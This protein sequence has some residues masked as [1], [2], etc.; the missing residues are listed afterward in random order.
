VS[1]TLEQRHEALAGRVSWREC[2]RLTWLTG[3]LLAGVGRDRLRRWALEGRPGPDFERLVFEGDPEVR[4]VVLEV[5]RGMPAPFSRFAI[6]TVAFLGI[7]ASTCGWAAPLCQGRTYAIVVDGRGLNRE[8]L[9]GVV[10]HEVSHCWAGDVMDQTPSEKERADYKRGRRA[11]AALAVQAGQVPQTIAVWARRELAACRLT[12]R[13][14]FRGPG[15]DVLR[16][17]R[18][19]REEFRDAAQAAAI[20]GAAEGVERVERES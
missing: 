13:L 4:D 6:E 9:A 16:A 20:E 17:R 2:V 12:A 11:W 19:V 5:L 3:E 15:A 8:D 14:G 18:A 7:G 1:L 10:A